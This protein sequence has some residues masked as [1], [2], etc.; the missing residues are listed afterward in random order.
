MP[1]AKERFSEGHLWKKTWALCWS[2]SLLV[3]GCHQQK[4]NLSINFVD[5]DGSCLREC[6]PGWRWFKTVIFYGIIVKF[7]PS[8]LFVV[9][10]CRDCIPRLAW[11]QIVVYNSSLKI[12][13]LFRAR[14][15]T[16][17]SYEIKN[18]Y[19]HE[20]IFLYVN[21]QLCFCEGCE[22][23]TSEKLVTAHQVKNLHS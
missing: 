4:T 17:E 8:S 16:L 3:Y 11:T 14:K 2:I 10:Y 23:D 22:D 20:T 6:Q 15:L 1:R 19:I 5:A 21:D 18:N 12:L 7:Y 13:H 9:V